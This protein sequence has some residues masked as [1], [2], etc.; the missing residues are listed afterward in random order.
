MTS[1]SIVICLKNEEKRVGSLVF[2]LNQQD[3][4]DYEIILVDD[5][6]T[7]R[8]AEIIKAYVSEKLR[9]VRPYR[10]IAGKKAAVQAGIAAAKHE[11]ILVTDADCM[12]KSDHWIHHMVKGMKDKDICLG[13]APLKDEGSIVSLFAC[14]ETWL[15]GV[16]YLGYAAIGIPYMGVGRNMAFRRELFLEN[17]GYSNHMDLASG[18]DD[19]FVNEVASG[20]NTTIQLHPE[21]FMYSDAPGSWQAFYRQKK[22][23]LSTATRYRWYHQLLLG[24]FS[25]SFMMIYLSL[26][27]GLIFCFDQWQWLV[28]IYLIYIGMKWI[29]SSYLMNKLG[30]QQLIPWFWFFEVCLFFYY[31]IMAPFTVIKNKS[32]WN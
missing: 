18:D 17:D 12:G 19:L 4:K 16:Q 31:I 15:T 24:V 2:F 6:S 30:E 27:T 22:R 8:T 1:V 9:I 3:Y 5:L 29:I 11:I 28:T 20:K 25:A 21:S 23:H 26:I 32:K 13:Y 14:F 7:D 10:D